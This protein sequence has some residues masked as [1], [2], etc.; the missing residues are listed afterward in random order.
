MAKDT[1]TRS[2]TVNVADDATPEIY[3]RNLAGYQSG[4]VGL[5]WTGLGALLGTA[6]LEERTG[7]GNFVDI[8]TLAVNLDSAA[9]TVALQHRDFGGKDIRVSIDFKAAGAGSLTATLIAKTR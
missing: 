6:K 3:F 1:Y 5:D 9:D 2:I 7:A 8:P 4:Q